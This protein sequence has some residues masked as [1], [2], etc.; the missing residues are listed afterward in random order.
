MTDTMDRAQRIAN[1]FED[2]CEKFEVVSAHPQHIQFRVWRRVSQPPSTLFGDGETRYYPFDE[3]CA[4]Q[5]F[6]KWSSGGRGQ[7]WIGYLDDKTKV[8]IILEK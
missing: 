8:T 3:W 7:F 6:I 2:H 5:T 1:E 4:R